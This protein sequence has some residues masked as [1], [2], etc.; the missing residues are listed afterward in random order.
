MIKEKVEE[1][2]KKETAERD[3]RMRSGKWNPGAMGQ[4]FR[5]QYWNRE[6]MTE[7]NPASI[8]TKKIFI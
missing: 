7:S 4:C 2:L 8:D 3:A 6:G 5:R 1:F